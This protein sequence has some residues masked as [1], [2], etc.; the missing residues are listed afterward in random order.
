MKLTDENLHQCVLPEG[1][2][3]TT[4]ADDDLPGFG[5][6]VRRD[7]K[8]RIRRTWFYQYRA[9]TDGA[10]HRIRLGNVDKP[11]AVAATLARQAAT[12]HWQ[13]VQ[14]GADPQKDRKAARSDRRRLFLDEALKY[15][16]DRRDG[17]VGKRP[18]RLSTYKA[19]KRYFEVH[20]GDLARRPVA[21]VTDA[22]VKEQLRRIIDRHGKTAANRA[23]GNLAAFYAWAVREG[24]TKTNPT[25]GTHTIAENPPRD[26]VFNDDEIRAIWS[27]CRDDDFGRIVRLLFFTGCRRDEIGGLRWSEINFD[28]SEITIPGART[29]SGRPLRLTLPAP[30][31][32][33][34]R[35]AP[36]R[37]NREFVFGESGGSFSR[38]SW[39]K[40]RIEKRL[41]EAGYLLTQWGL[42]DVRRTVRTRLSKLGVKPHIAELVIGHAAHRTGIVGTYDHHDYAPEIK[43]ALAQWAE[44][45][46]EIIDGNRKIVR[47]PLTA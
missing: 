31:L 3:D 24:I 27:V 5:V 28:A 2:S 32:Q 12:A 46:T 10:Q 9:R 39:E 30:A 8:G 37:I 20:W 40:V 13:G 34:L 16:A 42:H 29:K 6:R 33:V 22:E 43:D 38:W 11:G 4:Y 26:R 21:S 14:V 7:V 17:I 36:R 15:L 45:L 19:A 44:T 47:L 1:K 23:K 18:M 25:M 35:D 41:A